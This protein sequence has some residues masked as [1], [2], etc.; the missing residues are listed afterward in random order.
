MKKTWKSSVSFR[1]YDK[2]ENRNPIIKDL[3]NMEII[4]EKSRFMCEKIRYKVKITNSINIVFFPKGFI[5]KV[6]WTS[7]IF[8]RLIR[9]I[10]MR[11]A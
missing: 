8:N 9:T 6:N 3:N 7:N 10:T 5:L 2:K 1:K 11:V 4:G